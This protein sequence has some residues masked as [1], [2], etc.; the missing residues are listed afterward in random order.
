MSE[1][2]Q[3]FLWL[4]NDIQSLRDDNDWKQKQID[5]L[6]EKFN[7]LEGKFEDLQEKFGSLLEKIDI[8]IYR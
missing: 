2:E 3:Q 8:A 4:E 7:N 5:R 6:E 1:T